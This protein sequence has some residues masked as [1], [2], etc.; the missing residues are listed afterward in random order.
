MSTPLAFLA[1]PDEGKVGVRLNQAELKGKALTL[2]MEIHISNIYIPRYESLTLTPMLRKG[3]ESI[4]LKP[5]VIHGGNKRKM[6]KRRV[7]F[8]GKEMAEAGAYA[9][10]KNDPELIQCAPYSISIPYRSWMDNAELIL[11]GEMVNY[12][13]MPIVVNED[14]LEKSLKIKKAKPSGISRFIRKK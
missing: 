11:I 4:R 12:K 2:D 9:V 14:V 13:D 3:R 1:P 8:Q 6:H 10:L 5:V 7:V